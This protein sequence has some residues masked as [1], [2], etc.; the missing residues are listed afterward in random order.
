MSAASLTNS[1]RL[2]GLT[3]VQKAAIKQ[4]L[5]L[6]NPQYFKM[7]KM[8]KANRWMK[9]TVTYYKEI[10]DDLI[11]S[12]GLRE[13]LEAYLKINIP[14]PEPVTLHAFTLIAPIVLRNYQKDALDIVLKHREG[15]IHAD[16][17][18]GKSI[19]ALALANELWLRTLIIVPRLDLKRAFEADIEKYFGKT[20]NIKV[21]TVQY[22]QRHKPDKPDEYGLVIADE[23]HLQFPLKSRA[24]FESYVAPYKYGLTATPRRGDDGQT[25][26]LKFIFGNIIY[27]GVVP[28]AKPQVKIINYQD[29]IYVQDYH[30]MIDDQVNDPERNE[31][32]AE[33]IREEIKKNRKVLVITKR[34]AHYQALAALVKHDGQFELHSKDK[35]RSKL[36]ASLRSGEQAFSILYGSMSLVG[37]GVDIPSLDTLIIAGDLKSDIMQEQGCG[38]IQRLFEG[39]P[40]PL[41]IDVNDCLNPILRRQGRLRQKFYMDNA[42]SIIS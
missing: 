24:V 8:G 35:G 23:C 11:V 38:R 36:L 4:A 12:R 15:I 1:I 7:Q 18:W 2:G 39:K 27:R 22:L 29:K 13:R 40:T 33:I 26:A 28:R 14:P 21:E 19:L 3:D 42:W 34:V 16:T 6:A 32:I 30:L 10:D 37:T 41:I 31:M 17:G 5:T 20:E 9:P 25:E